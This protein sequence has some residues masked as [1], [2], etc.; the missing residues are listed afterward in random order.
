MDASSA[1]PGGRGECDRLRS[2]PFKPTEDLFPQGCGWLQAGPL[3]PRVSSVT[4]IERTA[5]R[6]RA[7]CFRPALCTFRDGWTGECVRVPSLLRNRSGL[8]GTSWADWMLVFVDRDD[9]SA[10]GTVGV[11]YA[12]IQ[13]DCLHPSEGVPR[14]WYS[15]PGGAFFPRTSRSFDTLRGETMNFAPFAT[16]CGESCGCYD[17]GTNGKQAAPVYLWPAQIPPGRKSPRPPKL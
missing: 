17:A 1:Q 2:P 6:R 3:A 16:F 13:T 5:G 12:R 11:H 7:L 8:P 15:G 14:V 4:A 9:L 10:A